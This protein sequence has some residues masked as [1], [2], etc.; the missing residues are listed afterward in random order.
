MFL[1]P[2]ESLFPNADKHVHKFHDTCGSTVFNRHESQIH[3]HRSQFVITYQALC[4]L[5]MYE[6]TDTDDM[7]LLPI[8]SEI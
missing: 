3:H 4:P 1:I 6:Y 5:G 2:S 7:L 8:D